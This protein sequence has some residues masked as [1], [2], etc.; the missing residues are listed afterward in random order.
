MMPLVILTDEGRAT[1]PLYCLDRSTVHV[2]EAVRDEFTSILSAKENS[3]LYWLTCWA[4][5]L[6]FAR[7]NG[8]PLFLPL[9]KARQQWRVF[10]TV[11][12]WSQDQLASQTRSVSLGQSVVAHLGAPLILKSLLNCYMLLKSNLFYPLSPPS[13]YLPPRLSRCR[14]FFMFHRDSRCW[15]ILLFHRD[16]RC[17]NIL[18]FHRDSRC[19][20]ILPFH[21]DSRCRNI[22]PFHRDSRCRNILPFHCDSRCWNILMFHRDSR[23]RNFMFHRD[24]RC[25]DFL[26][27]H[28]DSRC[29]NFM[30]HRDS[31]SRNTLADLSPTHACLTT[32]SPPSGHQLHNPATLEVEGMDN[33]LRYLTYYCWWDL[34]WNSAA[35]A[36][37]ER[38]ERE[39]YAPGSDNIHFSLNWTAYITIMNEDRIHE[40]ASNRQVEEL[41]TSSGTATATSENTRLSP[42]K[43]NKQTYFAEERVQI[44]VND[45]FFSFRKLWAFTGPGFLMSIAYLDP[46][47]IESDLQSGTTAMYKTGLLMMGRLGFES[48]SGLLWVV[49][50]KMVFHSP[51][52][53]K[54]VDYL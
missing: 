27:F 36:G 19:R 43:T 1:H 5:S 2:L 50:P 7:T 46:G 21:R 18:L 44:P 45:N 26:M 20:N 37:V 40:M 10:N 6:Q 34:T 16:S 13:T 17:W 28:R 48:W 9:D 39:G 30:F 41:P 14:D 15:N 25:R 51:S 11:I 49:F 53:Q 31:R 4:L 35:Q 33:K 12:P 38:E 47:N 54:Q 24:S 23:C 52:Q 22:L 42:S 3:C 8:K 32:T 29:R